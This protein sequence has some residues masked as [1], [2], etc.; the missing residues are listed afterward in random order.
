MKEKTFEVVLKNV[1]KEVFQSDDMIR[2]LC[3]N[4]DLLN[5][6]QI[7]DIVRKAFVSLERKLEFFEELSLFEDKE[8]LEAELK[9]AKEEK[10]AFEVELIKKHSYFYQ[11]EAL[12]EALKQLK[13]S[14]KEDG[15]LLLNEYIT[16][17][18]K[19][20]I[21]GDLPFYTYEK[22]DSYIKSCI[23]QELDAEEYEDVYWYEIEKYKETKDGELELRY[24]YFVFNG[25]IIYFDDENSVVDCDIWDK[26]LNVPVP[27]SQGDIVICDGKPT[28]EEIRAVILRTGDN[29]DCCSLVGL[30]KRKDGTFES[31]PVKHSSMF[32]ESRP[33]IMVPPLY[34][35]KR[36][37]QQ[38][39]DEEPEMVRIGEFIKGDEDRGY[40]VE[41]SVL[42]SMAATDV[43][44]ELFENL[45]EKYQIWYEK[46]RK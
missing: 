41:N 27:F 2:Y 31:T 11:A 33:M 36:V 12:K 35:I 26:D 8:E 44:D 30:C 21:I 1:I 4:I 16:S 14:D 17:D 28:C 45:E 37:D 3:Q 19:D 25:E 39:R 10:G 23:E 24:S 38:T 40:I 22:L 46:Y 32:Y 43:T 5:K 29:I 13:I 20:E 34:S 7:V 6:W 9:E 18:G 42:D 15:V